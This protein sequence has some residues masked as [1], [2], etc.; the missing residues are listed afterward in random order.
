MNTIHKYMNIQLLNFWFLNGKYFF[1]GNCQTFD[2]NWYV[3]V[4]MDR[5]V[6]NMVETERGYN[7]NN[8]SGI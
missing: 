1:Y 5:G 4:P 6:Q 2:W 7:T 3:I 8:I